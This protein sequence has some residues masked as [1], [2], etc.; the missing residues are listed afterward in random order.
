MV[1]EPEAVG[2]KKKLLYLASNHRN[3]KN[4]RL[5]ENIIVNMDIKVKD[6]I[7]GHQPPPVSIHLLLQPDIQSVHQPYLYYAIW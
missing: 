3:H 2:W 1:E 5:V 6:S 7:A 4:A